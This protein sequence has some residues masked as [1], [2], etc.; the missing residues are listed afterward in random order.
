VAEHLN[1]GRFLPLDGWDTDTIK[2]S[3]HTAPPPP[4]TTEVSGGTTIVGW[5]FYQIGA[6][7]QDWDIDEDGQ[8]VPDA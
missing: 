6:D 7:D 1:L 8:A 2:I 5:S 4:H 3:L